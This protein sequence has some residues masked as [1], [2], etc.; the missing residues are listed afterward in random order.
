MPAP[1][2]RCPAPH[3]AAARACRLTAL[4]I[5]LA[6]A[7]GGWAGEEGVVEGGEGG[8]E[9]V[10]EGEALG[11]GRSEGG[12]AVPH[13]A[14]VRGQL[15]GR[16][17]PPWSVPDEGQ[18]V[19]QRLAVTATPRAAASVGTATTA[20]AAPGEGGGRPPATT[21]AS[22]TST[23]PGPALPPGPVPWHQED[24]DASWRAR[25]AA[26]TAG[27][28]AGGVVSPPGPHGVG[29]SEAVGHHPA[30]ADPA[31]PALRAGFDLAIRVLQ[32][33]RTERWG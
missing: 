25:L 28:G 23:A 33:A 22:S 13:A 24:R 26:A 14:A 29:M 21:P 5:R 1:H 32:D 15:A 16:C 20:G 30:P 19:G 6:L 27:G 3:A 17:T 2:A 4:E 9:G 10:Q 7:A 18:D 8:G 12:W 31:D 11:A